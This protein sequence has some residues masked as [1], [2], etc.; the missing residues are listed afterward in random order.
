MA[1]RRNIT[2]QT[3]FSR[4]KNYGGLDVPDA[5]KLKTLESE[6][7]KRKRLVDEQLLVIEELKKFA[8]EN[9]DP[10]R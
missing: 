3:F 8:G 2:E 9:G 7:A 10:G 5:R 4:R 6:N 1:R